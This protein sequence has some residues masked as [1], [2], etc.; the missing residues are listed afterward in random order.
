[1]KVQVS[2]DSQGAFRQ[3]ITVGQHQF[4]VDVA[5]SAGGDSSAPDPHDYFDAAIAA[6]K[7]ITMLMYA[8]RKGMKVDTLDL[9]LERDDSREREGFYTLNGTLHLPDHLTLEQKQSLLSISERCP[10]HKL[11][12]KAEVNVH[13]TLDE[14]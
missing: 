6:C 12:T 1:M 9:T 13:V 3:V 7:A 11:A 10:V 5:E 4:Y 2:K 8:K 14:Q